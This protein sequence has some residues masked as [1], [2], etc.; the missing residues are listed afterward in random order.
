ML[1]ELLCQ[2]AGVQA[3]PQWPLAEASLLTRAFGKDEP[4]F[5]QGVAHRYVYGVQQGLVKLQYL[6]EAGQEWIKSFAHEGRFFASLAALAPQGRTS[7]MVTAV[8]PTT[9]ERL[10]FAVLDELAG[11]HLAWAQA[12]WRLTRAYAARK[13]AREHALLTRSAEE[14]YRA[15]VA[16]EP[17]LAQRLAQKDLARYLGVTAVGLNRIVMRVRRAG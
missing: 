15:F 17:E 9:L 3:L 7:F 11:R 13:E 5:Q 12:L 6:D 16:Q 14:R 2:A 8:E 4:V 10:D 1:K